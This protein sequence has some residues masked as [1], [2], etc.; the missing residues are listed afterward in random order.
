MKIA[1]RTITLLA[2]VFNLNDMRFFESAADAE[3]WLKE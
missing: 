1:I 3:S 2:G